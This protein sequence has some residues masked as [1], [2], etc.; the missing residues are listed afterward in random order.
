[1]DIPSYG[2][3]EGDAIQIREKSRAITPVLEA[4]SGAGSKQPLSWLEADAESF[5]A[6]VVGSP[7][8]AD[9]D[10]QVSEQLIV[11]FYSR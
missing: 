1:M 5:T 11:E 9:I 8:R 10:T 3:R 2:C 6:R 4:I 7:R